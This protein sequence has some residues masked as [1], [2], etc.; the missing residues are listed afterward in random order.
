MIRDTKQ[1][2][3]VPKV[4]RPSGGDRFYGT[5]GQVQWGMLN[6]GWYLTIKQT[7]VNSHCVN[8]QHGRAWGQGQSLHLWGAPGNLPLK[9]KDLICLFPV[10]FPVHII[11]DPVEWYS[12]QASFLSDCSSSDLILWKDSPN[13]EPAGPAE[14]LGAKA[15]QARWLHYHVMQT[16][17]PRSAYTPHS[18]LFKTAQKDGIQW[19]GINCGREMFPA[20]SS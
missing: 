6:S 16:S 19:R 14:Q 4:P 8:Q 13:Q 10:D 12:G 20:K 11:C 1:R 3:C 15:G 2:G 18:A 7:W 17:L 9:V 5:P